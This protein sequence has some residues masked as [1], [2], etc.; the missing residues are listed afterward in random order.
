MTY[1]HAK[2]EFATSKSYEE[3]RSQ[4]IHY[5]TIDLDLGVKVT[6]NVTQYPL[7]HVIY[8]STKFEV[9]TPNGLGEDTITRN[10]TDGR[11]HGQRTYFG[12]KSIYPIFSNEKG[13]IIIGHISLV[14]WNLYRQN[15]H[16]NSIVI[17]NI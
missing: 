1:A 14:F 11:T 3:M 16:L 5:L 7:H 17:F 8:A 12:T 10:V 4:K 13:V 15:Q 9:A 2:F 6:R